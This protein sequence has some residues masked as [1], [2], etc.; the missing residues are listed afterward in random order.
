MGFLSSLLPT[1][2][3]IVGGAVLPGLGNV[4]GGAFGSAIGGISGSDVSSA[5]QGGL[6]AYGAQ[7]A[8]DANIASAR[9]RMAFDSREAAISRDWQLQHAMPQQ[10]RYNALEAS[11]NR[12]FQETMSSSSHQREARDLAAAG[13]NRILS[14]SKG[15]P[16]ASTPGGAV[17]TTS[18]APGATAQGAQAVIKDAITP[19]LNTA[20]EIKATEALVAETK[21]RTETEKERTE[22]EYKRGR[23]IDANTRKLRAEKYKITEEGNKVRNADF[24]KTLVET[25]HTAKSIDKMD[26]EAQI[27]IE[28]LKGWKLEGKIDETEFGE[29]MRKVKRAL[30][31]AAGAA[32]AVQLLK[33]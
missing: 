10:H 4:I 2:G 19:A 29:M 33:R 32:A 7:K 26:K 13:L 12:V 8:N 11:R 9:E 21:Q 16:G 3:K 17:G 18:G 15:G 24:D 5:I 20:R 22:N 27:L 1:V 14:V 31:A 28:Q 6:S 23:E 30:P 25:E